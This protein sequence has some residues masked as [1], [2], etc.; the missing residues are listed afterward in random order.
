MPRGNLGQKG[1]GVDVKISGVQIS[2]ECLRQPELSSFVLLF[3][4]K[5]V[6]E[7]VVSLVPFFR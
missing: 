2:K 1:G 5:I 3:L 4:C 7:F 6:C